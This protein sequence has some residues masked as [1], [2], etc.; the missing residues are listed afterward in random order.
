MGR[1]ARAGTGMLGASTFN[2][3][4]F[5]S[6]LCLSCACYACH[7]VILCLPCGC[8]APV[9]PGLQSWITAMPRITPHYAVK[10]NPE[11]GMQPARCSRV[12]HTLHVCH[13]RLPYLGYAFSLR[14]FSVPVLSW[15]MYVSLSRRQLLDEALG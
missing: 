15:P 4:A 12:V 2:V 8:H 14:I 1:G 11:P 13:T 6:L 5:Y 10:C 7:A 9:M 3:W